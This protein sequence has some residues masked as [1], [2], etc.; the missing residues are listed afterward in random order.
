MINDNMDTYDLILKTITEEITKCNDG[1]S[2]PKAVTKALD[3]FAQQYAN[4]KDHEEISFYTENGEEITHIVGQEH[5]V[6]EKTLEEIDKK[7]FE[8]NYTNVNVDHNHPTV[9]DKFVPTFLTENDMANLKEKNSNGDYIYRSVSA[10]SPNGSRMTIL[11]NNKFSEADYPLFEKTIEEINTYGLRYS[12]SHYKSVHMKVLTEMT[13]DFEK[14]YYSKENEDLHMDTYEYLNSRKF[15]EE[16][17]RRTIEKI[18]TLED[19]LEKQGLLS[20]LEKA[21]CKLRIKNP[22]WDKIYED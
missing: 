20:D 3:N 7:L 21:N 11:R 5:G 22:N 12:I 4:L 16:A 13:K 14:W 15:Q 6:D 8:E 1:T 2:I 19:Y 18:G 9:W 17:H 10:E